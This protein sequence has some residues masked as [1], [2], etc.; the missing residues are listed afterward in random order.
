MAAETCVRKSCA[1]H[2]P[3]PITN[4][5]FQASVLTRSCSLM[6]TSLCELWRLN[7]EDCGLFSLFPTGARD[8]LIVTYCTYLILHGFIVSCGRRGSISEENTV[9]LGFFSC[10]LFIRAVRS[11]VKHPLGFYSNKES[12]IFM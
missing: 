4:S 8:L 5:L 12:N 7:S 1:A 2:E 9:C 3:Q 11:L 10:F 6:K